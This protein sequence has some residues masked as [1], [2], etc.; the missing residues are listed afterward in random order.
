MKSQKLRLAHPDK[1]PVIVKNNKTKETMKYLVQERISLCQ[2]L[3]IL[4]KKINLSEEEGLYIYAN[5]HVL[6]DMTFPM[7][8]IYNRHK[9]EKDGLLYLTITGEN[10][11]G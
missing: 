4:R 9:N 11:F 10:V 8:E 1:I 2:F 7:I 5:D 6:I 3:L